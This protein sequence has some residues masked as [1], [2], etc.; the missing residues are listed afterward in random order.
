VA[1]ALVAVAA[2]AAGCGGSS[3]RV[4]VVRPA[5]A[6]W[7]PAEVKMG[8]RVQRARGT[9]DARRVLGLSLDDAEGLGAAH[10]CRVRATKIDGKRQAVT[11][12]F[13][14]NRVNVIVEHGRVARF[15]MD[16]GGPVG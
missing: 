9:F 13:E 15:D 3:P 12:D 10:D 16:A 5:N 6:I 4:H 1:A 8:G 11:L 7:C 2:L 14:T